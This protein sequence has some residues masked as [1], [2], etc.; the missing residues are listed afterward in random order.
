[1]SARFEP[2]AARGVRFDDP[3]FGIRWPG[4]VQVISQRDRGY[5][6]VDL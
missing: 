1:M 2:L 4:P 3:A 6:D 5:P